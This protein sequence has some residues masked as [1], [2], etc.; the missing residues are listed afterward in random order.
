[1]KVRHPQAGMGVVRSVGENVAE[2]RFD[3]GT[4]RISPQTSELES[5]EEET[6]ATPGAAGDVV[7]MARVIRDTVDEVISQLNLEV[8]GG[9]LTGLAVR[10][11]DGKMVLHPSDPTLQT[12]E[13]PI[14]TFFH[15]IVMMRNNLRML[16]AKV[17]AHAG[18]SDGDK[19]ELHQYITRCYGSMTTFNVLFK[20]KDDQFSTK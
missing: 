15:K 20:D 3:D 6:M 14:E 13:V 16:E 2:I 9:T 12:K 19:F 17:N 5:A 4:R 1:M 8:D 18:L 11:K 7:P 10:W